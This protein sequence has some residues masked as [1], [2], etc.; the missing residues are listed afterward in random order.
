MAKPVFPVIYRNPISEAEDREE[1]YPDLELHP[2]M[3]EFIDNA[4]SCQDLGFLEEKIEAADFLEDEDRRCE[5][6]GRSLLEKSPWNSFRNNEATIAAVLPC[7]D[8]FHAECLEETT[9]WTRTRDPPCPICE[10]GFVFARPLE[11][12]L[13]CARRHRR[14]GGAAMAVP[15]ISGGRGRYGSLLKDSFKRGC[16]FSSWQGFW[17]QNRRAWT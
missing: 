11:E 13:R 8:I 9:P 2:R 4:A 7:G 3:E 6:C 17:R 14:N 5:I 15:Q 1:H 16:R 12:A 10:E